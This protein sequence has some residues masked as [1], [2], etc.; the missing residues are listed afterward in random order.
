M[1]CSNERGEGQVILSEN[2]ALKNKVVNPHDP[3]SFN[4]TNKKQEWRNALQ[5]VFDAL[6]KN[7]NWKFD[8][9]PTNKKLIGCKWVYRIKF[10]ENGSIE[11]YKARL[12]AKGYA[13]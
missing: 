6:L 11:K 8:G 9:L 10:K 3:I 12:V 2:L 4:E 5:V 1:T 7:K 13:Q